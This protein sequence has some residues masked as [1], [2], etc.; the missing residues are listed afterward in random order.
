MSDRAERQTENQGASRPN[1]GASK[2][3]LKGLDN[4]S[5]NAPRK[6][7]R[8][9]KKRTRISKGRGIHVL[10]RARILAAATSGYI[11]HHVTFHTPINC[12]S[13][14]SWPFEVCLLPRLALTSLDLTVLIFSNDSISNSKTRYKL[15]STDRHGF[16][17]YHGE[18][19]INWARV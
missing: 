11:E 17:F 2:I 4:V 18:S 14:N 3:A 16:K 1:Q 15:L 6:R 13:T 5:L 8:R 12:T 9:S 10:A 19:T 7:L